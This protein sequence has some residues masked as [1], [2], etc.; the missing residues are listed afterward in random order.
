M[1]GEP[2]GEQ[3]LSDLLGLLVVVQGSLMGGDVDPDLAQRLLGRVAGVERHQAYELARAGEF[4]RLLGR[5]DELN[6]ALR[7]ALGEVVDARGT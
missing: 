4:D 7:R 1:A 6:D 2:L 3:D 5:F